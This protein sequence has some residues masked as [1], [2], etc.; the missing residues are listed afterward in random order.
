MTLHDALSLG[1]VSNLPTV[2]ANAITA[3]ALAVTAPPT[4][5]L[6][7]IVIGLSL[8]YI[9]GMYLNDACDAAID[10]I[11]RPERPIPSGRVSRLTV[12]AISIT[13]FVIG[14]L[15]MLTP[16]WLDPSRG[17]GAALP[18]ALL[19][20]TCIVGYNLW[21]KTNPLSPVVMGLCRVMV[22]VSAAFAIGGELSPSLIIA[23]L[24][25]LCYLIGLTYAAKQENLNTIGQQWPLTFLLLP[26]VATL[27]PLFSPQLAP[28]LLT[29]L[30]GNAAVLLVT[31]WCILVITVL[32]AC[33]WIR[34][35]A[36]RDIPRAVSLLIA[37]MCL[38]DA[39]VLIATGHP[40][41]ALIAASCFLLTL[42]FQRFIAGT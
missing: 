23:A 5:A 28:T 2:W 9:A 36:P 7:L 31:L 22:Y 39:I 13:L 40:S 29:P 25:V 17:I 33:Y 15:F 27:V 4:V 24:L 21:H 37:G 41:A 8:Y 14:T 10:A 32:L 38:V 11:E 35:R 20:I 16:A 30:S 1:R 19:L 26:I 6:L 42:G 18:S 12:T 34:R 3:T